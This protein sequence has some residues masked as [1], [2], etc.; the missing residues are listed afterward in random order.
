MNVCA[1]VFVCVSCSVCNWL[2]LSR[3]WGDFGFSLAESKWNE[4]EGLHRGWH[5]TVST[6]RGETPEAVGQRFLLCSRSKEDVFFYFYLV[7]LFCLKTRKAFSDKNN[8]NYDVDHNQLCSKH[9]H[10]SQTQTVFPLDWTFLLSS[11]LPFTKHKEDRMNTP[12]SRTKSMPQHT[13]ACPNTYLGP[14][15]ISPHPAASVFYCTSCWLLTV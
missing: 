2:A 8:R 11:Y 15:L 14:L 7:F 4:E 6:R 3:S 12:G 10:T 5:V 1:C 13:T 9:T